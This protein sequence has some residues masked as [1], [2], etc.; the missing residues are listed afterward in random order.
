MFPGD[1][2]CLCTD[3]IAEQVPYQ[4]M[5]RTLS[6]DAPPDV[7]ASALVAASLEAGG[8][9]KPRP[10]SSRCSEPD[11][12]HQFG[13]RALGGHRERLDVPV[14]SGPSPSAVASASS[15][16]TSRAAHST[17]RASAEP[18]TCSAGPP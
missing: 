13:G 18:L 10:S 11:S 8:R 12:D 5:E 6:S 14:R 17:A 4:R 9:D 16:T 2:Y 3:G 1:V 15:A 7:M